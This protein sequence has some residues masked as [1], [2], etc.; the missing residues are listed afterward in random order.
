MISLVPTTP[1]K[2]TIAVAVAVIGGTASVAWVAANG[3]RDIKQEIARLSV[4]VETQNE[5]MWTVE[6]QMVWAHA[7]DRAN[8]FS[9]LDVPSVSPKSQKKPN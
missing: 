5:K 4:A 3:L 7:L 1:L 2:I 9:S 8:R 6:D